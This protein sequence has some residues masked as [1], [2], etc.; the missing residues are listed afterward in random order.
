MKMGTIRSPWRHDYD[1]ENTIEAT[2][3]RPPSYAASMSA[4]T[5][6]QIGGAL[7]QMAFD[8]TQTTNATFPSH[9]VV[10]TTVRT[11]KRA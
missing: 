4:A 11:A 8:C 5:P 2:L 6:S 7:R 3:L 10:P 9:C 1:A